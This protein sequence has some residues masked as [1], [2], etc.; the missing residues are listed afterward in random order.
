MDLYYIK[1]SEMKNKNEFNNKNLKNKF[2]KKQNS[3]ILRSNFF[4]N[5]N[6][7]LT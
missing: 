3:E 7:F 2:I 6:C 1:I 4:I 5:S